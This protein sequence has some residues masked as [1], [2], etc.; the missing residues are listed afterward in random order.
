M[1]PLAK[2]RD[3]RFATQELN[4]SK[5]VLVGIITSGTIVH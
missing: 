1:R 2:M 3:A 5:Q 4:R